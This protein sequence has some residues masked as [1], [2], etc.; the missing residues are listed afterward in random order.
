MTYHH[1][2]TILLAA[3][4]FVR[5][6]VL[7]AVPVPSVPGAPLP[8]SS[9]HEVPQLLVD[10][11]ECWSNGGEHCLNMPANPDINVVRSLIGQCEYRVQ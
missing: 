2:S 8:P 6:L 4:L 11:Y 3:I 9:T 5:M 10:I 7:H 1:G